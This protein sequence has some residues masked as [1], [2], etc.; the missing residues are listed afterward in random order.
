MSEPAPKGGGGK[1]GAELTGAGAV[2]A[3][4]DAVGIG[5]VGIATGAFSATCAAGG[6]VNGGAVGFGADGLATAFERPVGGTGA[7]VTEGVA[8]A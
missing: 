7:G 5:E 4:G 8:E 3:T 2:D 1:I 6:A